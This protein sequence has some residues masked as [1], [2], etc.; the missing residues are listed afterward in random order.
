MQGDAAPAASEIVAL[1]APAAAPVDPSGQGSV[2]ASSAIVAARPLG[3][4]TTRPSLPVAKAPPTIQWTDGRTKRLLEFLIPGQTPDSAPFHGFSDVQTFGEWRNKKLPGGM[5][6]FYAALHQHWLVE[7]PSVALDTNHP[8]VTKEGSAY[9]AAGKAIQTRVRRLA[10][11]PFFRFFIVVCCPRPCLTVANPEGGQGARRQGR[12]RQGKNRPKQTCGTAAQSHG[13]LPVRPGA[14]AQPC[15]T[16][17]AGIGPSRA[18][19]GAGWRTSPI[20]A[21]IVSGGR[22]RLWRKQHG[23]CGGPCHVGRSAARL[24]GRCLR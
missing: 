14:V 7:D 24:I 18:R 1:Q 8:A 15:P 23:Q 16:K 3:T 13:H 17:K 10:T 20:Y 9:M 4:L 21:P 11:L 6:G 19:P 5:V 22:A 2:V 12:V